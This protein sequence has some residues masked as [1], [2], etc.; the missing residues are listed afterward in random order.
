MNPVETTIL[1]IVNFD[2][3]ASIGDITATPANVRTETFPIA[4][5]VTNLRLHPEI[6]CCTHLDLIKSVHDV[7]AAYFIEKTQAM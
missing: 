2:S 4:Q 1:N 6:R 7:R 3:H 5:F